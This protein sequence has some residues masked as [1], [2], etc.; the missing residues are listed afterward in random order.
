MSNSHIIHHLPNLAKVGHLNSLP[1]WQ[2]TDALAQVIDLRT[3]EPKI[4]GKGWCDGRRVIFSAANPQV[5][6]ASGTIGFL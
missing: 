5:I 2:L 4:K 6:K 1:A 3:N